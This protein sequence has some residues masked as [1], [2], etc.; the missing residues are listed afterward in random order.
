MTHTPIPQTAP[1]GQPPYEEIEPAEVTITMYEQSDGFTDPTMIEYDGGFGDEYKAR[2]AAYERDEWGF[3]G[4]RARADFMIPYGAS[5]ISA[6]IESPGL[7]GVES[8]SSDEY[9]HELFLEER[10]TL[11]GMLNSISKADFQG[12]IQPGNPDPPSTS[13]MPADISAPF[14]CPECR[15]EWGETRDRDQTHRGR[16]PFCGA[17]GYRSPA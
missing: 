14:F 5:F 11:V 3:V 8:D 9:K 6:T 15:A 16:C 12:K 10:A 13:G 4:I 7:W 2:L 1:P 17:Q